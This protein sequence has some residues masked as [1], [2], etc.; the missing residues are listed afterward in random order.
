MIDLPDAETAAWMF[1]GALI[2]YIIRQEVL[3]AKH[4]MTMPRERYINGIVD[5]L[6]YASQE[7]QRLK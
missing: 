3:Q 7:H 5:I 2:A 1:N 6:M 4:T